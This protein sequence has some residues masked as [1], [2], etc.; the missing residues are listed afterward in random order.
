MKLVR[1]GA[2][3]RVLRHP[4]TTSTFL[5]SLVGRSAYALVFLPLFFSAQSASSSIAFAGVAVATYGAGASFLAPVRAWFID[6]YG[7]RSV[8]SVLVLSFSMALLLLAYSSMTAGPTWMILVFAGLG[9]AVAPPLGPTMRVAWGRLL[10]DP[11]DRKTGLSLDAVVEELLYLAGPAA[12]GL[13]LVWFSPGQAL[14]LPAVLVAI[15]G[16][17]FANTS[18]VSQMSGDAPSTHRRPRERSLIL[19][20]EFAGVLVPALVAG[21]TAGLISIA[22]PAAAEALG[23]TASVGLALGVFAGG[24]A[25]GGLVYGMVTIPAS[26]ARQLTLL[27]AL[28]VITTSLI[29][30]ADGRLTLMIILGCAGLFFSPVMIVAY[31]AAPALADQHQQNAATTWVNT[32]HNLGSAAVSATAGI[33]IESFGTPTSVALICGSA[34]LLVVLSSALVTWRG[35]PDVRTADLERQPGSPGVKS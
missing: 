9:G 22:V 18:V 1:H 34:L 11:E 15:G 27:S 4:R 3:I 8:L 13:L 33:L 19:R 20:S 16:I 32:S 23:S 35:V 12:A 14:L 26:P 31:L 21:G 7:A 2:Y 25:V 17:V 29:A 5:I 10:Q 30:V 24:S 28:F 6:R